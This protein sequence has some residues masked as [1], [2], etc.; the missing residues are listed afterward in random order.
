MLRNYENHNPELKHMRL[1]LQN[2]AERY[3]TFQK[4]LD[5]FST[6]LYNESRVLQN[7]IQ[8]HENYVFLNQTHLITYVHTYIHMYICAQM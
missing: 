3:W 2:I 5:M 7:V 4:T 8:I 6:S 1:H